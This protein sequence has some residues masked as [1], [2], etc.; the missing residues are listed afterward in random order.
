MIRLGS[1]QRLILKAL[2]TPS[3]NLSYFH[4]MISLSETTLLKNRNLQQAVNKLVTHGLVITK[5]LIR[6]PAN[7]IGL[8]KRY[9]VYMSVENIEIEKALE[10]V[11]KKKAA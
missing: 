6:Q 5:N 3:T 10:A 4:C 8:P 9:K 7:G 2:E 1:A 11:C